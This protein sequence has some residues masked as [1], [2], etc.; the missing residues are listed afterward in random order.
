MSAQDRTLDQYHELMQINAVSH[1]LRA[2]RELGLLQQLA[3][4]Q[5]TAE[6]LRE[7]LKLRQDAI[8][9]LLDALRSIGI[10]ERYGD[11][12]ALSTAARLLCQ[13][14]ADLGDNYW[15][16]LKNH[17]N[18]PEPADSDRHS[19][20]HR[21]YNAIAATQWI[22]TPAAMQAAEILDLANLTADHVRLLDLGCG[23]GVWSCAM[24]YT[25]PAIHV[26]FVDEPA[27]LVAAKATAD[28]INLQGRY[29]TL[30][31]DPFTVG[32]GPDCA[33]DWVLLGQRLHALDDMQGDRLLE[34][35]ASQLRPQGR[36][37]VIDLFRGPAKP[38]LSESVEA[39]KLMLQTP[40]GQMRSLEGTQQR[41]KR[42]GFDEIQCTFLA[43]SRVNLG[44]VVG[45][46][47]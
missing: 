27:A 33:Y 14:D 17:L 46:R 20:L 18:T 40:S 19:G 8:H 26:T 47:T 42:V 10:I 31:G 4:G 32:L 9:L 43:N 21:H 35:A 6:Q 12:Y 38:D 39:L 37:V 34:I 36:L 5:Q 23:S 1:I 30:E 22:H 29:E 45:R 13:Y 7:S 41:L 11:D 15:E 28:S 25:N 16:R 44:L 24:A 2:A 3:Q